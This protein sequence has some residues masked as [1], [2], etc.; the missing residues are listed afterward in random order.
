MRRIIGLTS[1]YKSA[2]E[3]LLPSYNEDTDLIEEL[4]EMSDFQFG[5]YL[6]ARAVER[7]QESARAKK[8]KKM[9]GN[10]L[11]EDIASTYRIFSRLFCNFVFPPEIER[12]L[13]KET[14]N[15]ETA[16]NKNLGENIVDNSFNST[17]HSRILVHQRNTEKKHLG[18]FHASF[19]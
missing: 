5:V 19:P 10:E 6:K 7:K 16:I 2:Q 4:I 17:P 8:Q 13:P 1:F 14:D 3:Q 9:A 11:Y 12:P 18:T 15:V